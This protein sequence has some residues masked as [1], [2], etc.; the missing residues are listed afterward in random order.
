V[1]IP[2]RIALA[3]TVAVALATPALASHDLGNTGGYGNPL[4]GVNYAVDPA[5]VLARLEGLSQSLYLRAANTGVPNSV[6]HPVYGGTAS[7]GFTSYNPQLVNALSAFWGQC[8]AMTRSGA[9]LSADP[10]R[11]TRDV[12]YLTALADAVERAIAVG[13]SDMSV[14]GDWTECRR[15]VGLLSGQARMGAPPATVPAGAM[16][17]VSQLDTQ[18]RL[19]HSQAQARVR[20]GTLAEGA[21]VSRLGAYVSRVTQLSAAINNPYVASYPGSSFSIQSLLD[22]CRSELWSI[23]QALRTS[24]VLASLAPSWEIVGALLDQL[25]ATMSGS[26]YGGVDRGSYF[27]R[28]YGYPM[29]PGAR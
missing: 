15:L 11:L 18:V 8:R 1:T 24:P 4:G 14:R 12:S 7:N 9:N 6:L 20:W 26:V 19:V 23:D 28:L 25:Q 16:G 17:I 22:G 13:V 5:A 3:L 2:D 27:N 21:I 29:A 10:Y